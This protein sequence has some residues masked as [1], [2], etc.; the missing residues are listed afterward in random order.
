MY[1]SKFVLFNNN[2][3]NKANIIFFIKF[4]S[5]CTDSIGNFFFYINS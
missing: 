3:K 2:I 5:T 1:K 4:Q